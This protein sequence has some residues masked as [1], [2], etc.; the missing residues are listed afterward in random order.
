MVKMG[1]L[2]DT[3]KTIS[4]AEKRGKR[5]V[6]IRPC[7]K[8][9]VKF[10]QVM[11][12]NG[13]WGGLLS[14]GSADPMPRMAE[15]RELE[16]APHVVLSREVWLNGR[17]C[18]SARVDVYASSRRDESLEQTATAEYA[19]S[20]L[21]CVKTGWMGAPLPLRIP[22]YCSPQHMGIFDSNPG[23]HRA[24][25]GLVGFAHRA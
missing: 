5:Q 2:A 4:N 13:E 25:I 3:L 15:P 18:S 7:S 24:E 20:R 21:A 22:A 10:L 9:V 6:L 1:V 14:A 19:A 23:R 11:Q 17:Y 8:V 16:L 12:K